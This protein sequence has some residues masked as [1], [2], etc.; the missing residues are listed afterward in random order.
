MAAKMILGMEVRLFKHLIISHV[1][2]MFH[3]KDFRDKYE[4]KYCYFFKKEKKIIS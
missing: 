4:I 1:L 3:F 2:S